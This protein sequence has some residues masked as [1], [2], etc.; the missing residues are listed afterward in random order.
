MT[1]SE[2]LIEL[3]CNIKFLEGD[4]NRLNTLINQL[5]VEA[6]NTEDDLNRSKIK[7]EK[8]NKELD[9]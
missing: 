6:A 5:K 9:S 3:A 4:L 7:F 2:E 8:L 1:K